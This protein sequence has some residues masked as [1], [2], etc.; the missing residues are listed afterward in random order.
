M[1]TDRQVARVALG[2][3]LAD[4]EAGRYTKFQGFWSG[5][6][7]AAANAATAVGVGYPE[8][9]GEVAERLR[10]AADASRQYLANVLRAHWKAGTLAAVVRKA[11][12]S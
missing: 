3:V 1:T 6:H 9:L 7:G 8:V 11:V 5:F 10:V 12:A 4:L 2:A